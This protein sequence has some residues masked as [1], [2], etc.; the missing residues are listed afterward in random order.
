M[1]YREPELRQKAVELLEA[2]QV[3]I[4]LGLKE[5]E[6]VG[7]PTPFFART[8]KDAEQLVWNEHCY[9]NLAVY[10]NDLKGKKTAIAAK[11]GDKRSI[12]N[13]LAEKQIKE[14]EVLILEMEWEEEAP[15]S[16]TEWMNETD[17]QERFE[18]FQREID[19]C[20]LCF[21]C[22]QACPNCYCESCYLDRK[23]TPWNLNDLDRATKTTYHLTRAMHLAGRCTNC[24]GCRD[25]CDFGVDLLYL[26][27]GVSEFL[28]DNYDFRAG[29]SVDAVSAMNSYGPEDTE[30]G[31]LGGDN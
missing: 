3:D 31:F 1:K 29:E 6:D 30:I 27:Q 10:L 17:T 9:I 14:D 7:H 18:R 20:T 19:K 15:S 21:A 2:G 23:A 22:R 8:V 5:N 16:V 11:P 24:G 28:D 25:A 12:I 26:M 13:L 4:V